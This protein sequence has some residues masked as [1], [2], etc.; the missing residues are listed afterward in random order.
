MEREDGDENECCDESPGLWSTVLSSTRR[1]RASWNLV[2]V[3]FAVGARL[4][5]WAVLVIKDGC[6]GGEFAGTSDPDLHEAVS[7]FRHVCNVSGIHVTTNPTYATAQLPCK[8]TSDP[9]RLAAIQTIKDT[10][11]NVN[12][13][14]API[15]VMLA[16][17]DKAIYDG[18]KYLCDIHLDVAT[19]CMQSYKIRKHNPQYLANVSLKVNVK[20]G[21]VNHKLDANGGEWLLGAPTMVVGIDVTH[22][23]RGGAIGCRKNRTLLHPCMLS[24]VRLHY[25][26]IHRGRRSKC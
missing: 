19:V 16:N 13:N 15:V 10:L 9:T 25:V 26:S 24:D 3:K 23:S 5:N 21:G 14:P 2:G 17:R 20:P 18:V 7:S 1:D 12:P 4:D 6:S 8:E 22:H 11:L